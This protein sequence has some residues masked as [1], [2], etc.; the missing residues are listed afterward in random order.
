[1]E[2]GTEHE[3]FTD[4]STLASLIENMFWLAQFLLAGFV[5]TFIRTNV[6]LKSHLDSHISKR[7]AWFQSS[8]HPIPSGRRHMTVAQS[9]YTYYFSFENLGRLAD[10]KKKLGGCADLKKPGCKKAGSR[11]ASP[12]LDCKL[13]AEKRW[14]R[15]WK[16]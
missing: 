10:R 8:N 6:Y 11:A 7:I 16:K 9:I 1:M 5:Y 2:I 3:R 4:P 15:P 14:S 13:Q 12:L